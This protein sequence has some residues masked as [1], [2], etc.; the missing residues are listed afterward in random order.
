MGVLAGR[1]DRQVTVEYPAKA[2]DPMYG[3]EIV[4]WKP[5]V[6]RGNPP[7]PVMFWAQVVDVQPSNAEILTQGLVIGRNRSRI[8]L[9]WRDDITSAMR[10]ILH[11]DGSDTVMQIIDGPTNVGGR[12]ELIEMVCEEYSS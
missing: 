5:L 4:T 3:T 1:L 12:Q 10:V 2:A 9:R 11:R 7:V 8:R 6:T